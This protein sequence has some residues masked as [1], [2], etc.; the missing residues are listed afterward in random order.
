[1]LS[2]LQA[3]PFLMC[4]ALLTATIPASA[5]SNESKRD[6]RLGE[7]WMGKAAW[8]TDY[9]VAR[10][11][12]RKSGKVVFVYFTLSYAESAPSK[13]LEEGLFSDPKF[14]GWSQD[15]VLLCHFTTKVRSDPHQTLL[16]EKGGKEFP[17]L[18]FLDPEGSVLAAVKDAPTVESIGKAGTK[19]REIVATRKKAAAGD[20]AAMFEVLLSDVEGERVE[21]LMLDERL[22]KVGKLSDEQRDRL[23]PL[24]PRVQVVAGWFQREVPIWNTP[25]NRSAPFT[26]MMGQRFWIARVRFAQVVVAVGEPRKPDSP[27]G[28]YQYLVHTADFSAVDAHGNSIASGEG[29]KYFDHNAYSIDPIDVNGNFTEE[30][31]WVDQEVLFQLRDGQIPVKVGFRGEPPAKVPTKK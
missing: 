6:A 15:F 24:I 8:F 13:A 7:A 23:R 4:A 16:A 2:K 31:L 19:A 21:G 20:K 14:A 18:A 17:Y 9:D 1:M 28:P 11:E 25:N 26:C 12:A 27:P 3:V 22:K 30:P 10:Q 5:Q 29:L